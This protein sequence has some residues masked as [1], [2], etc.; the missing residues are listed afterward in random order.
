MFESELVEMLCKKNTNDVW[1][2]RKSFKRSL[3]ITFVYLQMSMYASPR[4]PDL[5][6]F[7]FFLWRQI[8]S[9]IQL[10][11]QDLRHRITKWDWTWGIHRTVKR[12]TKMQRAGE[13]SG[14]LNVK[15]SHKKIITESLII[16]WYASQL[17]FPC[18]F[19]TKGQLMT[20]NLWHC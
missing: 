14:C 2:F 12:S 20:I 4:S 13:T 9:K 5:T 18:A 6:P 3:R 16:W 8:K 10:I 11:L 17:S 1:L 15:H 19:Q 7:C